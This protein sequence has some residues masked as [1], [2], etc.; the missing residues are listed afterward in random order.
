MVNK[1]YSLI[2]CPLLATLWS[3]SKSVDLERSP[4]VPVDGASLNLQSSPL[5]VLGNLELLAGHAV[6][7]APATL[8][9]GDDVLSGWAVDGQAVAPASGVDVAVDGHPYK[10]QY[11]ID[12]PDVAGTLKAPQY[13]KSGFSFVLHAGQMSKGR[14]TLAVRVISA[15]RTS[16]TEFHPIIISNE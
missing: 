11:G 9:A 1:R 15:N 12:R 2:I 16:Y 13:E 10:A 6:T 5:P 7:A 3:C 14:H 8:P 4:D